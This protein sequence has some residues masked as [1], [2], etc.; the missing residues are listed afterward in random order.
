M[1]L[2]DIVLMIDEITIF[3]K[4]VQFIIPNGTT[5]SK[6]KVTVAVVFDMGDRIVKAGEVSL[7]PVF[8]ERAGLILYFKMNYWYKMSG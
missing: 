3:C 6:C 5:S 2:D 4:F 8:F 1:L 7:E